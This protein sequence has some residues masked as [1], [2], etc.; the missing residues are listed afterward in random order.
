MDDLFKR[1]L[2]SA[3]HEQ[4]ESARW[5]IL[6][7]LHADIA[8]GQDAAAEVFKL[9]YGDYH[10]LLVLESGERHGYAIQTEVEEVSEGATRFGPGTLYTS[11]DRLLRKG[12]IE[13]AAT[14]QDPTL[15]EEQRQYYRLTNLGQKNLAAE[16]E[17]LAERTV[18]WQAGQIVR[19]M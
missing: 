11:L 18:R 9:N 15:N 12:L 19:P 13:E 1:L 14:R 5:S 2:P 10:I 8:A 7:R 4:V 17:R 6:D 16:S 3:S